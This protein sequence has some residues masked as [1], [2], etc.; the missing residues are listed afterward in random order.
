MPPKKKRSASSAT[1][2][3]KA[4]KTAAPA[5]T[6]KTAAARPTKRK[7]E[8][9]LAPGAKKPKTK[10]PAA[11]KKKPAAKEEWKCPH[12][13]RW[14][15]AHGK[16][17][18]KE[19][20]PLVVEAKQA[21]GRRGKEKT[22][23]EIADE[24]N[25]ILITRQKTPYIRSQL[26]AV[27]NDKKLAEAKTEDSYRFANDDA[28]ALVE[29]PQEEMIYPIKDLQQKTIGYGS[30]APTYG[31]RRSHAFRIGTASF[32]IE[33][34]GDEGAKQAAPAHALL[35]LAAKKGRG[36]VLRHPGLLGPVHRNISEG[37]NP[38]SLLK[39]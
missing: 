31:D 11:A 21:L 32:S 2:P 23:P 24:V 3:K 33:S 28:A 12:E 6:P 27:I 34:L 30:I 25:R 39:L 7:A 22:P 29:K 20:E 4:A 8:A 17:A 19:I 37:G 14:R 5:K 15:K 38:E 26:R 36:G 9:D 13:S 1:K 18:F 10:Q 16:K 35:I